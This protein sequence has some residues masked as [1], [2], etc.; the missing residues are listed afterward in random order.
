MVPITTGSLLSSYYLSLQSPLPKMQFQSLQFKSVKL[1]C[2]L[3]KVAGIFPIN[4][5]SL[6]SSCGPHCHLLM[7]K[8]ADIPITPVHSV[9][10]FTKA[11]PYFRPELAG[12]P[13][14]SSSHQSFFHLP[15]PNT[16]RCSTGIP[17]T[18][19]PVHSSHL[20]TAYQIP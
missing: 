9:S 16:I 12:I 14:K 18:I 6:L 11:S 17:N 2:H 15:S 19:T 4:F 20:L 8:V 13:I 7:P 10:S 5:S 3:P 1:H